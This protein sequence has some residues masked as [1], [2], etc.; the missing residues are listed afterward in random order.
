MAF[1]DGGDT[2]PIGAAEVATDDEAFGFDTLHNEISI[3]GE[4]RLIQPW[5]T[6]E[7]DKKSG[8]PAKLLSW[9]AGRGGWPFYSCREIPSRALLGR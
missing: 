5:H 7:A 3:R 4:A 2:V 1:D 9:P 8:L 6:R